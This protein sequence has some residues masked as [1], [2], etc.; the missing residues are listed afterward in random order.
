MNRSFYIHRAQMVRHSERGMVLIITLL[1][2]VA[3]LLVSTALLRSSDTSIQ[4]VSNLS[5][6]QAAEA[7]ANIAVEQ[8]IQDFLA[9]N[10]SAGTIATGTFPGYFRLSRQAG[11]SPEGIP[12]TLLLNGVQTGEGSIAVPGGMTVRFVVERMC[13]NA[14]P[15][16]TAANCM[17][18]GTG[19][20]GGVIRRNVDSDF[21]FNVAGGAEPVY[22]V[23]IRVDGTRNTAVFAQAFIN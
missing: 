3:M 22:R 18:S 13:A 11:E 14:N 21:D 19:G 8:V 16:A 2:M 7:S 17:L 9:A 20:P 4:V 15:D 5:F 10:I 12:A 1:V 6:R 23:S